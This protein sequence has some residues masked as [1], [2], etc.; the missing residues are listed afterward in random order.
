[1]RNLVG[2][3]SLDL[4]FGEGAR[5]ADEALR[6]Q[7]TWQMVGAV[8][9]ADGDVRVVHVDAGNGTVIEQEPALQSVGGVLTGQV[10][11]GAHQVHEESSMADENDALLGLSL[12]I[13]VTGQQVPPD[14]FG[15]DLAFLLGLERTF[16][17]PAAFIQCV[18]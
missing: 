11:D 6:Y 10:K 4:V 8:E 14:A 16:L 12:F 5:Q 15:A 7:M 13:A 3:P 1:M 17:P 2:K 18:R 9:I